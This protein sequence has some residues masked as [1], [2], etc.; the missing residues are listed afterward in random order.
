[1]ASSMI[2]GF[3]AVAGLFATVVTM[4]WSVLVND[5]VEAVQV[6]GGK[7]VALDRAA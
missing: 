5:R 7:P 3:L 1:M 2:D 4:V 6:A